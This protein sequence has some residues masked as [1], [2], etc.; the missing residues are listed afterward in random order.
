[1]R[2]WIV[3]LQIKRDDRDW[4]H[5]ALRARVRLTTKPWLAAA[6][7]RAFSIYEGR[8]G[9]AGVPRWIPLTDEQVAGDPWL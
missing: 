3:F 1:M 6:E 8:G 7:S 4:A 9:L 2:A 5:R